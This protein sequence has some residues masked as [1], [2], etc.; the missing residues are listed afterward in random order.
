MPSPLVL[1]A[2]LV[3]LV[4]QSSP[5]A[6]T[7]TVDASRTVGPIG[8]L[9]NVGYNGWG[10]ITNR[11]MVAAFKGI[12]VR[13][14]RIDVDLANL[15]GDRAGD[16]R[17]EYHLP[18][19]QG[20]TLVDRIR[21]IQANG[22]RPLLAFSYH[23][24]ANS[25]PRWFHG[26]INDTNQKGWVRFNLDGSICQSGY[27]DQL[28]QAGVIARDI[29]NHLAG[30]GLKG[31]A[32]ETLYEMN[33]DMPLVE[34]HHAIAS[35]VRQAD[36]TALLVGPA[37]WPGWSVEER[38]VK[39][40]LARYGADLVD[41]VSVHWYGSNDHDLWKLWADEK[42]GWI[43]GM[44]HTRYLDFLMDRTRLFGDWTRSL[45]ALLKD[46]KLN[47]G[48]K[49]I[50]ILYTEIDVNA[51][52]YFLRNPENPDWPRYRPEC[53]CWLNTNFWGGVW[54]SSVL[55]RI[56]ATGNG[57]GAMKFNTRNY[58]GLAEMAAGDCAY[59][60]PV[61]FAMK[62][63]R[64]QG[65][66]RVGRVMVQAKASAGTPDSLE[67]YA[68]RGSGSLG[69]V[70]VNKSRQPQNTGLRLVGIAPGRWSVRR[71]LFDETRVA[72]MR[73]RKPGDRADGTFEGDP[74]DDS[75][76]TKCLLPVATSTVAAGRAGYRWPAM[77]LPPTS[78]TVLRLARP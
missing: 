27:G 70:L 10:D 76:S 24:G 54:W 52:S 46:R 68:T 30:E 5:P 66:V 22:W 71:F 63:L 32:W 72:R 35:G 61:W 9:Y 59:R 49:R 64:D 38:F 25:L 28:N 29:A 6:P 58:Y 4:G 57:A 55:C 44:G 2:L 40:Y 47:P 65:G 33:P 12:G 62:L 31:L 17:W 50:G 67:A 53:D 7:I 23:G 21:L 26:E 78:V 3:G 51:T 77:T 69:V 13:Y 60:Y 37:T 16:Y 20:T 73:G 39:P 11:G 15:C 74:D 45:A 14:C 43:L 41:Q 8:D 1:I 18:S 48:G 34:M 42:D 19:D 75:V 56:A 36:P